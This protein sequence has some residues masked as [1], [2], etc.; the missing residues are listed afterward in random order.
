MNFTL[1]GWTCWSYKEKRER[2]NEHSLNNK[3]LS[4]AIR[5]V[6]HCLQSTSFRKWKIFRNL[7]L[8]TLYYVVILFLWYIIKFKIYR[9]QNI[10]IFGLQ[11]I[12]NFIL[13]LFHVWTVIIDTTSEDN[14]KAQCFRLDEIRRIFYNLLNLVRPTSIYPALYW[15]VK[16]IVLNWTM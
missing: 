9:T 5:N 15:N 10:F 4:Y 13:M 16:I 7:W 8:T 3:S 11:K 12:L 1:G 2:N 6:K 14:Q